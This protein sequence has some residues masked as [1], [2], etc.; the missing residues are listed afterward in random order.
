MIR[1]Y[2]LGQLAEQQQLAIE[3][4]L[5]TEDGLF[6]ELEAI[7]DELFDDYVADELTRDDRKQFEQYFL[8]TPAR[9]QELEFAAGLHHYLAKKTV[10]EGANPSVSLPGGSGPIA[11]F[12]QTQL[13][14]MAAI[15][16]F[17]VL[18][19][20]AVWF[21]R[22]DRH[23]PTSYATFTLTLSN[24]NR[25]GGGSATEVNLPLTSDAVRLYLTLPDALDQA[26]HFRVELLKDSGE[27]VSV[28]KVARIEQSAV[29]ELAATQLS[30]GQ[31][32]LKLYV[33]K[34]DGTEERIKGSYFLSVK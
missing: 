8:S 2:L 12:G 34:P 15:A 6:E 10:S 3:Q 26:T 20:G 1:Q 24:D 5:L 17:V 28:E 25:A 32:A 23:P 14:R 4:R 16:A 29:I 31:Y 22:L 7:E 21:T 27:T 9:R 13:F 18:I 19:A 33:L 30:R 11:W